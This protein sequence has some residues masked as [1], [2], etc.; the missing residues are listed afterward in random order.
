M[1]LAYKALTDD[2]FNKI[3]GLNLQKDQLAKLLKIATTNQLLQ[4]NGQVY[5][6]IDGVAM[7]SPRGTLMANVF[8]CHLE[9]TLTRDDLM[10]YLYKRYVDDTLARM[11]SAAAAVVLLI[12]L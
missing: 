5:E 4:F 1:Y 10:L 3:N 2:W 11:P 12:T 6:Q 8:I 9:E 7:G